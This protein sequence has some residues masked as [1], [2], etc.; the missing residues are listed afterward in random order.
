MPTVAAPSLA[1]NS[2]DAGGP[3]Y[4]TMCMFVTDRLRSEILL[5]RIAAGARLQHDDVAKRLGVSRMPVREALRILQ[6]EGLVELRPHRGAVVVDLRVEDIEE[7]FGI[8][9]QLEP[10]ATRLGVARI[11]EAG[12]ARLRQLDQEMSRTQD[13]RSWFPLNREFHNVLYQASRWRR[14]CGLIESQRNAVE[15][16]LRA[17]P[18]PMG[19]I[20]V[21]NEEHRQI[22]CW[23]EERDGER[24][25]DFMA[26]HLRSTKQRLIECLAA[27]QRSGEG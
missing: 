25:A 16:Y 13:L 23:V 21:A 6:S 20:S 14:L 4:R 11:D 24:V 8:R 18:A 27:R 7:I 1:N 19:R 17:A 3:E 12:V 2:A 22:L 15:P 10:L 5:G 9:E 26:Q